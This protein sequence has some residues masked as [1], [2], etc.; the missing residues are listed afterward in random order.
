MKMRKQVLT[1]SLCL[2]CVA[3][4]SLGFSQSLGKSSPSDGGLKKSKSVPPRV[5]DNRPVT[6][7]EASEVFSRAE[8]TISSALGIK[9]HQASQKTPLPNKPVS[10]NFV[11]ERMA[12]LLTVVKPK[13]RLT[14]AP[15]TYDKTVLKLDDPKLLATLNKLVK[16]GAVAKLGPLATGPGN[17]LTP[18][19]FGDA[20]GF[21]MARIGQI[22]NLPSNK[23]TP[24][25]QSGD[26]R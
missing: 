3:A 17:T 18:A 9:G 25:L 6:F 11:I 7:Q 16:L 24:S 2:V 26:E 22:T 20:V 13:V 14:P 8:K 10:R 5:A 12:D 15:V 21:F 4:V 23:W 19:Q 1:L